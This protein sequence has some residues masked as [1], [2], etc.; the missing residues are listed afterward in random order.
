LSYKFR[1]PSG[2]IGPQGQYSSKIGSLLHPLQGAHDAKA[3]DNN[4]KA[5]GL[6]EKG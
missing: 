1:W 5:Y 6:Q 4:I 3:R 2:N